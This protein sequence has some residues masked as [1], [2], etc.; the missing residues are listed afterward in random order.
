MTIFTNYHNPTS[1]YAW[2]AIDV[3]EHYK[4]IGWGHTEREAIDDLERLLREMAQAAEPGEL[5]PHLASD[6][7]L[8]EHIIDRHGIKTVLMMV[9]EIC[10]QKAEHIAIA[11]QDASLAKRWATLE[12]AIG[13]LVPQ[14]DGL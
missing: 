1:D 14:A 12:G 3:S 7:L 4:L 13:V 5:P 11:W 10:G 8:I 9:S 6:T 2:S